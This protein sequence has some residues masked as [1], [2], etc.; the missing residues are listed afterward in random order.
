MRRR[1]TTMIIMTTTTTSRAGLPQVAPAF[2]G[3]ATMGPIL[4]GTTAIT[5]LC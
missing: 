5:L 2:T 1:I 4:T 3:T